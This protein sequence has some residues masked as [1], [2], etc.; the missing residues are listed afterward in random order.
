M[1]QDFIRKKN[2]WLAKIHAWVQEHGGG[3]M[4]PFSVE[5]EQKLW[6]LREDLDGKKAFLDE[7][8]CV[9]SLP[10]MVVQGYK[11]LDLIYY[12]TAGEARIHPYRT[13]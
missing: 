6:S 2:K 4:I 3:N 5:W 13:L 11:E 12:F 10:K 7:C 1:M 8:K 9:S